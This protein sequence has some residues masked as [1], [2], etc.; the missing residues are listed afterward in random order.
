MEDSYK[1]KIQNRSDKMAKR[2]TEYII[3]VTTRIRE[4]CCGIQKQAIIN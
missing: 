3:D 2:L 4:R 1:K